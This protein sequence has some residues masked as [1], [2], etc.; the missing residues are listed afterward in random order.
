MDNHN[1]HVELLPSPETRLNVAPGER[2]SNDTPTTIDS[3]SS[4]FSGLAASSIALASSVASSVKDLD[5]RYG[6]SERVTT[7]T[8]AAWESSKQFATQIDEK[9]HIKDTIAGAADT[10]KK[11]LS[12]ATEA[13]KSTTGDIASS[14]SSP[15][16]SSSPK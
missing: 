1:I 13:I 11:Q 2:A 9:Y 15:R 6:V 8:A 4:M 10:T 3:F 7:T 16:Q 14:V 12:A 5:Q